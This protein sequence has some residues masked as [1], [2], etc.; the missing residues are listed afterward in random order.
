[1]CRSARCF[2][3]SAGA[4]STGVLPLPFLAGLPSSCSGVRASR[5]S[6]ISRWPP[7]AA[8]CSAVSSSGGAVRAWLGSGLG[9]GLGLTLTLALTLTLLRGRGA[10]LHV[11][12][13]APS[14]LGAAAAPQQLGLG[15][16]G[17]ARLAAAAALG[18]APHQILLNLLDLP[19]R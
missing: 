1:M 14:V 5:S 8:R 7:R 12:G 10:R 18:D 16:L 9:L 15:L 2:F 17:S 4:T 11:D 19:V 6:H 13:A 3:S